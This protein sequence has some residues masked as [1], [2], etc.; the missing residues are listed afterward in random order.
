MCGRFALAPRYNI[1]PTSLVPLTTPTGTHPSKWGFKTASNVFLINSR[2]DNQFYKS[3]FAVLLMDGYYE[4]IEKQPYYVTSR[5]GEQLAVGCVVNSN[6][7]FLIVTTSSGPNI[8]KIHDRMP[9]ILR[10]NAKNWIEAKNYKEASG[11][12]TSRD[13]DLVYWPVGKLINKIGNE[14]KELVEKVVVKKQ[15]KISN[16]FKPAAIARD[17]KVVHNVGEK[18]TRNE[19]D[20]LNYYKDTSSGEVHPDLDS[21]E[22]KI[23]A[24][25]AIEI[26][27]KDGNKKKQ[28]MGYK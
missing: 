20:S 4:W 9:V 26:G 10:N 27:T 8:S 3:G 25:D 2:S 16:F 21:I 18:R 28:R 13:D 6:N 12:I 1:A 24:K 7:E 14:G 17:S 23:E 5:N 11:L 15:P 19:V 22:I